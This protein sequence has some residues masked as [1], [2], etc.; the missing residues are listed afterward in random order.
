[1]EE[2][3]RERLTVFKQKVL[4]PDDTLVIAADHRHNDLMIQQFSGYRK[5]F[6]FFGYRFDLT[7]TSALK[8]VLEDASLVV[9]DSEATEVALLDEINKHSL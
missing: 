3:F 5:I 1:W 2:L 7:D 4:L 8:R 6:S 9:T